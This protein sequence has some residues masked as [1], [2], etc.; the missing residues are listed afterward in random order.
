MSRVIQINWLRTALMAL[1][2]LF[3]LEFR[4][5]RPVISIVDNETAAWAKFKEAQVASI[6]HRSLLDA[7]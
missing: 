5:S 1:Q 2:L 4:P 3:V 6:D 7:G